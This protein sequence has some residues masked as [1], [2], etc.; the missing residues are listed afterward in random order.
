[1]RNKSFDLPKSHIPLLQNVLQK[2]E[3]LN[4]KVRTP[5]INGKR[6]GID[7]NLLLVKMPIF[8][9]SQQWEPIHS[10]DHNMQST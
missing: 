10:V 4:S 1:M 3:S 2:Q 5:S 9:S 6:T 8:S 7:C